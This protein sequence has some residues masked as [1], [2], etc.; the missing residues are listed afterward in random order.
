LPLTGTEPCSE[1]D[2]ELYY[3]DVSPDPRYLHDYLRQICRGCPILDE[4]REHAIKHE[5]WGFWGG[6]SMTE[7]IA[8]RHETGVAFV[9][10]KMYNQATVKER[11][12]LA[13]EAKDHAMQLL[14]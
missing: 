8:I 9:G 14:S 6:L 3:N 10:V 4:C 1:I 7:R 13:K 11:E 2:P 12:R 5:E